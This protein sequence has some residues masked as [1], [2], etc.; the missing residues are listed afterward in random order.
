MKYI[1]LFFKA[2]QGFIPVKHCHYLVLLWICAFP[3]AAGCQLVTPHYEPS[4]T[5]AI[6]LELGPQTLVYR[7]ALDTIQVIHFRLDIIKDAYATLDNGMQLSPL[8]SSSK[9][10]I[11]PVGDYGLNVTVNAQRA[12][13]LNPQI[14]PVATFYRKDY[15]HIA[16]L[17]GFLGFSAALM[18][19]VGVL[20]R[21]LKDTSFYAYSAYIASAGTFFFIQEGMLNLFFPSFILANDIRLKLVFAGLTVWTSVRF[22]M[23]L[24]DI[25]TLINKRYGY[26]LNG[27]AG[28]VLALALLQGIL[29]ESYTQ[30]FS[31][32]M[33]LITLV[34]IGGILVATVYAV[35]QKVP[36]AQ[37]VLV[38]L[39]VIFFSMVFRL[40][41]HDVSPF[42][43]RYGLIISVTIEAMLL[44]I[45]ASEKVRRLNIDKTR[46]FRDASADSLCPVLNRRG[47]ESAA[48]QMLKRHASSGGVLSL[49]F[50]D[51]DKFKQINDAYG[52]G[53]GDEVLVHVATILKE[54]C[55]E[56][57]LVGRLGGD[58][59]VVL[60]YSLNRYQSER[61]RDR[62]NTLCNEFVV[63][64]NNK[65]ITLSAS[66]GHCMVIEPH[67]N[68]QTL[69][70][71]A[72]LQ[73]YEQKHRTS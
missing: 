35:K 34:G 19:F 16:V 26:I 55:R 69:L 47:W 63:D 49:F 33:G 23:Q 22:I 70:H 18:I 64:I 62:L 31:G 54:Q 36:A 42:L 14:E 51:L 45:A 3:V 6:P 67:K 2:L 8:S 66:L 43:H 4:S 52:H 37:L 13:F 28:S 9:A 38:S 7:C 5:T 1:G 68:I 58:E 56:Q 10:F 27:A 11:L 46:A 44:A 53:V 72:D 25:P 20:G 41:L 17:S 40:Y 61:L 59:F 73:M 30:S 48:N 50:I 29:P 32:I 57:D 15:I 71:Q 60:G 21:S 39:I 65:T 24:L 12:R